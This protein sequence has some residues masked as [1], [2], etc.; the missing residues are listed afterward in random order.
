MDELNLENVLC[1]PD[2]QHNHIS[3]RTLTKSRHRVIFENDGMVNI[4][5]IDN[6]STTKIGHAI[7]DLFH[8]SMDE[9]YLANANEA[10]DKY[11][12]WHH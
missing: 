5:D 2:L 6:N 3:V 8:L 1:I 7:G 12:L 10:F 4:N 11:A 9:A